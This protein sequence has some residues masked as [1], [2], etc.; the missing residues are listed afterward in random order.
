M[1]TGCIK[2]ARTPPSNEPASI[3]KDRSPLEGTNLIVQLPINWQVRKAHSN[4]SMYFFP[5]DRA[6]L[7]GPSDWLTPYPD[8]P[9]KPKVFAGCT[10]TQIRL[11]TLAN[12]E[13]WFRDNPI[14][15]E[16]NQWFLGSTSTFQTHHFD[17][18]VMA[19][20]GTP[21]ATRT[22]SIFLQTDNQYITRVSFFH[23]ADLEEE[24]RNRLPEIASG[25]RA[26]ASSLQPK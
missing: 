15:S 8:T 24:Q 3:M 26:I 17:Q 12:L 18:G 14:Y 25:C 20:E 13:H 7:A 22:T 21:N 23:E 1:G 9:S 2:A 10:I 5:H 11:G 4:D 19:E 6:W 16:E